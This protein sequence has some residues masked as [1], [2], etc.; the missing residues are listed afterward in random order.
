MRQYLKILLERD[1]NEP[2]MIKKIKEILE[3][4]DNQQIDYML[5]NGMK[6]SNDLI[7]YYFIGQGFRCTNEN[8]HIIGNKPICQIIEKVLNNE[9]LKS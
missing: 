5:L 6:I 3:N 8:K 4:F 9:L 7:L 1:Y 2:S